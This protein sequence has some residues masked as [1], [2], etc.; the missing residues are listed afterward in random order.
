MSL[1]EGMR[2]L[3]YVMPTTFKTAPEY[4]AQFRDPTVQGERRYNTE[5]GLY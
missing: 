2:E 5:S 3:S 4:E 1:Q